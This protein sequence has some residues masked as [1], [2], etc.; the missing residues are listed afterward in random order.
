MSD[1]YSIPLRQGSQKF[2]VT[3][4][5]ELYHLSIIWRDMWYLDI[6]DRNK[7]PILSGVAM[8]PDTLLI[9]QCPHA[10]DGDFIL[11]NS[12]DNE[13][14]TYADMGKTLQLYYLENI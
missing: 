6:S 11:I 7:K 10:M 5:G 8:V 2:S 1:V 12:G 14:P 3:L 9:D 13:Y 4:S